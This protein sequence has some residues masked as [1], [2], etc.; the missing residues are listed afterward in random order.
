MFVD[1]S[2]ENCRT[3]FYKAAIAEL[4]KENPKSEFYAKAENIFK[5]RN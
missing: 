3:D 2:P 4:R 5:S 1:A